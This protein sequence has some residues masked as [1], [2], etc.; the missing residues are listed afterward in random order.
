MSQEQTL[1]ELV[2]C[3][4]ANDFESLFYIQEQIEN[5]VKE[6]RIAEYTR[7]EI[8]AELEK[9]IRSGHIRAYELPPQ[10][11]HST[12]VE[13]N[14]DRLGELWYLVSAEGMKDVKT[15]E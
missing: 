8:V 7:E 13:Y 4:T 12:V 9:L 5:W 2:L 10:E 3:S 15:L 1:R 11:P 6:Q 14:H